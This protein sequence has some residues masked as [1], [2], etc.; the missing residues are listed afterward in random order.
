M[1]N[2]KCEKHKI[3]VTLETKLE[4]TNKH[5]SNIRNSDIINHFVVAESAISKL[6]QRRNSHCWRK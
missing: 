3:K 1:C 5:E 4:L 6:K 2:N